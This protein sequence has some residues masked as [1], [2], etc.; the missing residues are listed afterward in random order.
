M[1][2]IRVIF[3]YSSDIS[4]RIYS[5]QASYRSNSKR[6]I[7]NKISFNN[8]HWFSL[9]DQIIIRSNI[10]LLLNSF[11]FQIFIQIYHSISS[12][13]LLWIHPTF[14]HIE[15]K[16]ILRRSYSSISI[17]FI[18]SPSFLHRINDRT[19]MKSFQVLIHS[20][21]MFRIK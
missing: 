20:T 4:I 15:F 17:L 9:I 3:I 10:T 14:N 13:S 16:Q 11:Q 8:L 19:T 2:Q 5:R 1:F 18:Q 21:I 7:S 6:L 12:W